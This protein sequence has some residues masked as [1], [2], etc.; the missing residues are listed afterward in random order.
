[1]TGK[2][3]TLSELFAEQAARNKAAWDDP[4]A[5]ARREAR[6]AT[7]RA[8]IDAEIAAGIRDA[9]GELDPTNEA[10]CALYDFADDDDEEPG[11]ETDE[12]EDDQ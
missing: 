6:S 4:E 3:V 12:E 7:Y 5:V 11:A 2:R 1:M 10:A 9:D 8:Q